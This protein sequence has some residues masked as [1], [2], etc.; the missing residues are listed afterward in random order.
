MEWDAFLGQLGG[1]DAPKKPGPKSQQ[2][3]RAVREQRLHAIAAETFSGDEMW[4]AF[5]Q[6]VK[7]GMSVRGW[8]QRELAYNTGISESEISRI[9]RCK[10]APNGIRIFRI[11]RAL[12]LVFAVKK[13]REQD[14]GTP[15]PVEDDEVVRAVEELRDQRVAEAFEQ[16]VEG[17]DNKNPLGEFHEW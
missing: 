9:L 5:I 2:G 14:G 13:V 6:L 12:D 11:M 8:N 4:Q 15:L 17:I 16:P 10:V 3:R 7:E 1:E